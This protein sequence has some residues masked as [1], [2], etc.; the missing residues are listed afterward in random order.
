MERMKSLYQDNKIK[1]KH[2]KDTLKRSLK[3]LQQEVR[4]YL[5]DFDE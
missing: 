4:P 2:A 5:N 3:D 1:M